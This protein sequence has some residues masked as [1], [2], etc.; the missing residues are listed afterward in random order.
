METFPIKRN[1]IDSEVLHYNIC[2]QNNPKHFSTVT[3]KASKDTRSYGVSK[4]SNGLSILTN[5]GGN[6]DFS[7]FRDC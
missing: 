1:R 4:I 7:E 2:P 5:G 6:E 3:I